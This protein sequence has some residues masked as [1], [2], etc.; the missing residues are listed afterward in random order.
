MIRHPLDYLETLWQKPESTRKKILI[1]SVAMISGV[2]ITAWL[3]TFSIPSIAPAPQN[4]APIS[5]IWE[6]LQQLPQNI[7]TPNETR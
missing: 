3:M 5:S 1:V 4:A 2:V 7:F 6:T